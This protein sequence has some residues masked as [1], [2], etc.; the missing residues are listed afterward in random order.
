MQD[1]DALDNKPDGEEQRLSPLNLDTNDADEKMK[2][3]YG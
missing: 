3:Y 1:R 2:R